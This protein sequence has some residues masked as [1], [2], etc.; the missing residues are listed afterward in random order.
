MQKTHHPDAGSPRFL[1]TGATGF[2]GRPL[3]LYLLQAGYAVHALVRSRQKAADLS[4]PALTLFEGDLSRPETLRTAMDGCTHVYHLAAFAQAWSADRT[5]FDRIN[6]AGGR[7]LLETALQTGVHRVVLTSTGGVFGP[8]IEG[9]ANDETGVAQSEFMTNYERSKAKLEAVVPD[10]VERGLDVVIVNPTRVFGP[11]PLIDANGETLVM[12][13]YL[14]GNFRFL[15]GDGSSTG[16]YAYIDDVVRGHTLAMDHGRPGERYIL[17]GENASFRTF[18]DTIGRLSGRQYTMYGVP[19]KALLLFAQTQLLLAKT[20]G[21]RPLIT[22]E[23][24]RKYTKKWDFSVEKARKELGYTH[25]SLEES[26]RDT[27]TWMER[28][29]LI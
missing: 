20:F 16:S 18:F 11:G 26:I 28:S 7:T 15:P 8:S 2:I 17:G 21:S 24:V 13:R 4:H 3:T 23:L 10:F 9:R 27:M 29:G 14:K 22:P 25:R 12:H 6:Y 19:V 1:V 5:A